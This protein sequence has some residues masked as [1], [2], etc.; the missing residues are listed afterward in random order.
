MIEY[1]VSIA[2]ILKLMQ[3][4]VTVCQILHSGV[5]KF[6]LAGANNSVPMTCLTPCIVIVHV[7]IH[8]IIVA[9]K[10]TSTPAGI[11]WRREWRHSANSTPLYI[12]TDC[13]CRNLW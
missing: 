4:T 10:K 5:L 11:P 7:Y 3:S 12:S 8:V 2:A 1:L 9:P 13:V 6:N